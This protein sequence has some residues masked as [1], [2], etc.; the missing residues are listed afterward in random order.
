MMG[1]SD[2]GYQLPEMQR[3]ACMAQLLENA[4]DWFLLSTRQRGVILAVYIVDDVR[5]SRLHGSIAGKC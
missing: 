2:S 4:K 3:L 5:T 1:W